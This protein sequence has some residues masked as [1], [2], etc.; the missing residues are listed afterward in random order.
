[1]LYTTLQGGSKAYKLRLT[2]K[3]LVALESQL[4]QSLF[5]V[6]GSMG[7]NLNHMPKLEVLIALL[8]ASLQTYQHGIT[9]DDAYD[10]Y[11]D[12][13]EQGGSYAGMLKEL[14]EVLQISGFFRGIEQK[15]EPQ[16]IEIANR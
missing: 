9:P 3:T 5:S 11:D 14:V 8:H 1:M 4:G 10:I 15:G 6:F 7:E 12:Y 13:I 16:K 2:A